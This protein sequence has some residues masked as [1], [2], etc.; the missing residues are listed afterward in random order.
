MQTTT[1]SSGVFLSSEFSVYWSKNVRINSC[2]M[3]VLGMNMAPFETVSLVKSLAI[4]KK[5]TYK[6]YLLIL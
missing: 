3:K 1:G 6:E 2:I 5:C 4:C